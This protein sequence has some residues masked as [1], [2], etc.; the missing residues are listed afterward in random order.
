[1]A[2]EI[3]EDLF[4]CN[5]PLY[6][7]VSLGDGEFSV[8]GGGGQARTGVPNAIVREIHR[9]FVSRTT[10]YQSKGKLKGHTNFIMFYFRK[11]MRDA[12][13]Y[14]L[15]PLPSLKPFVYCGFRES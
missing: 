5:F 9:M 3:K 1:M 4:L 6:T 11:L 13:F 14:F 8:A 2:E 10:L 15:Y 7:I 12:C